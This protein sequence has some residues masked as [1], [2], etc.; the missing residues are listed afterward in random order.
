VVI[1]RK[2]LE[3]TALFDI[4]QGQELTISYTT[5]PETLPGFYGFYCNCPG[6]PPPKVAEERA[7]LRREPRKRAH[8]WF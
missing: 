3:V 7:K 6:C 8:N 2:S 5:I 1:E 4:D